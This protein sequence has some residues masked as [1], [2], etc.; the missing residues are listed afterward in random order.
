M[1][2]FAPVGSALYRNR[3][4]A[5]QKLGAQLRGRGVTVGVVLGLTRGGVP[6]AAAIADL[7]GARL[8]VIV[9]KKIGAPLI[10]E[11]AIGAV[12]S[13]GSMVLHEEAIRQL[14]VPQEYVDHE[15]YS[16]LREAQVAEDFFR[17]GHRA[18]DLRG[19][20]V[21]VVDDGVATGATMEAAVKSAHNRG[22]S[23]VTVAVPVASEHAVR[24]LQKAADEV[25][26]SLTPAEFWAVG[27]F[28]EDFSPV[29]NDVVRRLLRERN[30][31]AGVGA[32]PREGRR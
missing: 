17:E 7:L 20:E 29:S 32:D 11:M 13:D 4:D 18:A 16:Q 6:V 8:D 24:L 1:P 25:I 27:Q 12:C 31:I 15:S 26:S 14:Q 30:T 23:R 28:Y 9:V 5:G 2:Y 3:E 22:A 19:A 10:A 21:L